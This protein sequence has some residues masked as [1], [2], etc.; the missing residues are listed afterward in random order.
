MKTGYGW[1]PLYLSAMLEPDN[2]ELVK[3]IA[4]A[5]AALDARK[6]ELGGTDVQER[7]AIGNALHSLELLRAERL[8]AADSSNS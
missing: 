4:A 5:E 2:G 8:P 3:R 7:L 1:E 6:M